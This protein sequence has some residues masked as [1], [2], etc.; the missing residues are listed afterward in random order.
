M[1]SYPGFVMTSANRDHQ[2][3]KWPRHLRCNEYI[4]LI[5]QNDDHKQIGGEEGI[6]IKTKLGGSKL[7]R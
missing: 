3:K 4:I 7:G 2:N 6:Q 1:K 5:S